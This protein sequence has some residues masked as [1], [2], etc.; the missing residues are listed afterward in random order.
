MSIMLTVRFEVF[1][2]RRTGRESNDNLECE[3]NVA[4]RLDDDKARMRF[5]VALIDADRL[6]AIL[7]VGVRLLLLLL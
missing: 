2:F 1:E 5:R 3:P 6:L 4:Y 7:E